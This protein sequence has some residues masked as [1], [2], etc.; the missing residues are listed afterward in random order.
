MGNSNS[1]QSK[2]E[3]EGIKEISS[4]SHFMEIHLPS[5]GFGSATLFFLGIAIH[6]GQHTGP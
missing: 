4:G 1:E 5:M 2:D 6:Q 3:V